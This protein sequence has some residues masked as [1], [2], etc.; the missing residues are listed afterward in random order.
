MAVSIFDLDYTLL[1]GD[2]EWLWAEYLVEKGVAGTDFLDGMAYFFELYHSGT[3]DIWDYQKHFLS[4]LKSLDIEVLA[5]F[6]GDFI[7]RLQKKMRGAM[8][9]RVQWHRNRGHQTILISAST[10]VLVE[11]NASML[12]FEHVISTRAEIVCGLPT[13]NILD[14]PAYQEGKVRNLETWM[15]SNDS[16]YED[17]WAY[18]DSMNDRPLLERAAHPVAVTP[19][20]A[21]RKMALLKG[22]LILDL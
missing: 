18:S 11:P 22:W 3:L 15:I 10:S 12:G 16:T 5:D 17:S 8:L 9:E 2:T 7:T 13:G 20:Q 14:E 4:P 21:L 6:Q 1:E 19:D